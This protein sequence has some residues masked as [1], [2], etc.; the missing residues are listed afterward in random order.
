MV[1]ILIVTYGSLFYL[2]AYRLR[3]RAMHT[4]LKSTVLVYVV[5]NLIFFYSKPIAFSRLVLLYFS[6]FLFCTMMLWRMCYHLLSMSRLG[7]GLYSRRIAVAGS[8][9]RVGLLLTG[10]RP[11]EDRYQLV[12]IVGKIEPGTSQE[13]HRPFLG[14]YPELPEIVRN[15]S[16]D[17]L[18]L[19]EDDEE[20]SDWLLV[21]SYLRGTGVRLRLLTG[22]LARRLD[23]GTPLRLGDFPPAP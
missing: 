20:A 18:I 3:P 19:V 14:T 23:A 13:R 4:A 2:R 1:I 15:F 6:L 11:D 12:G 21:S 7:K 5:L 9:E 22:E 10:L 17:E 8:G 16:I